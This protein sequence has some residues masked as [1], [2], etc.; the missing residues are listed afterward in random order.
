MTS[1][2][3]VISQVYGGGGN[4]GAVFTNDYIELFNRGGQA[5]NITGWSVQYTGATGTA[6]NATVLSGTLAPGQYYLVQQAAGAGTPGPIPVPDAVGTTN[7]NSTAGKVALVNSPALLSGAC[8]FGSN[9]IDFVGFGSSAGCFEGSGP[10]ANL[11]AATAAL[12]GNNG[13]LDTNQN[14]SNFSAGP[15]APRNSL[16][17]VNV[18]NDVVPTRLSVHNAYVTP[19]QPADISVDVTSLGIENQFTFALTFDQ[20]LLFTPVASCGTS[21]AGCALSQTV[22]PGLVAITVAPATQI[23]VGDRSIVKVTFQTIAVEPPNAQVGFAT[24][25]RSVTDASNNQLFAS[26]SPPGQVVFANG[27]EGDVW[28]TALAT[29]GSGDGTVDALDVIREAQLIANRGLL[30]NTVNEF[31][32]AD[33]SDFTKKGDGVLDVADLVVELNYFNGQNGGP[34]VAVGGP[35]QPVSPPP[36]LTRAD[37]TNGRM[38]RVVS[39]T[40]LKGDDVAVSVEIDPRGDE[41]AASFSLKFDPEKLSIADTSG[42]TNPDITIG[43]GVSTGTGLMINAEKSEQGRLGIVVFNPAMLPFTRSESGR[44]VITLRFHV[45]KDANSGPTAVSFDDTSEAPAA[46]SISNGQAAL[47]NSGYT[48]GTVTIDGQIPTGVDISGRVLTPD[49]RGL[50]NAR[51]TLVDGS[52]TIRTVTTNS[53]GYYRVD[54]MVP[55]STCTISVASKTYSFESRTVHVSDSLTVVD[56]VGL[57]LYPVI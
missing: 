17:P 20:N 9:V 43:S 37:N 50:R 19:G 48:D 11:S 54:G 24:G 33:A 40:A 47:L 3:I 18:C 49:G 57:A 35:M 41:T 29:P 31:Q 30:D 5:V 26:Y 13:C 8:P 39:T 56:F 23:A 15:P 51:V 12:R 53:F 10:T 7:L 16:T 22:A 21:A 44:E 55:G 1:G 32:R 4:S 36:P 42:Q 52:K 2:L 46:L 14:G 38:M 34:H 45:A 28:H 27:V 6:W 25:G